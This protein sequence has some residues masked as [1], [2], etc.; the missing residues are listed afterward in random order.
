MPVVLP[1]TVYDSQVNYH[2]MNASDRVSYQ[3][4][5]EQGGTMQDRKVAQALITANPA[6]PNSEIDRN[7]NR[8]Q[9]PVIRTTTIPKTINDILAGD[10]YSDGSHV[11]DSTS[12]D[13]SGSNGVWEGT[14]VPSMSIW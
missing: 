14:Q 10:Y 3:R 4:V 8:P 12:A 7:M 9:I 1:E 11:N 2:W 13:F 5:F 6:T